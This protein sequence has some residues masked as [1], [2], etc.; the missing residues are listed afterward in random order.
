MRYQNPWLLPILSTDVSCIV[1]SRSLQVVKSNLKKHKHR[2]TFQNF[3]Q[4]TNMANTQSLLRSLLEEETRNL[5]QVNTASSTEHL[6]GNLLNERKPK[7]HA[8]WFAKWPDALSFLQPPKPNPQESQELALTKQTVF[9]ME[10]YLNSKSITTA[11]GTLQC[12]M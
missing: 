2:Q 12:K 11:T 10:V 6:Y 7:K 1:Q 4:K 9:K 3:R 5:C 8:D